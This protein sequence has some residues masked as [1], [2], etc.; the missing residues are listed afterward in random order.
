MICS[1]INYLAKPGQCADERPL[2][3]KNMR[4]KRDIWVI[5][6]RS[7][8]YQFQLIVHRQL[9]ISAYSCRRFLG[10]WVLN[11]YLMNLP[12]LN[13]FCRL[14]DRHVL[15]HAKGDRFGI[16][17]Y[18][19]TMHL[20]MIGAFSA[21]ISRQQVQADSFHSSGREAFVGDNALSTPVSASVRLRPPSLVGK[22]HSINSHGY[23]Y[24]QV[25]S[26]DPNQIRE[27]DAFRLNRLSSIV[28]KFR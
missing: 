6:A 23:S 26:P 11:R 1:I 19:S 28:A 8:E 10:R 25:A 13:G 3:N 2:L 18:F 7:S 24:E 4:I 27:P 17:T 14:Y 21:K 9:P 5:N 12:L 20:R 15:L 16:C 22:T